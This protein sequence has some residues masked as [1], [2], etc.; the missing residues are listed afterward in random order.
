M[1]PPQATREALSERAHSM[2]AAACS[3]T[4]EDRPGAVLAGQ[5]EDTRLCLA[6]SL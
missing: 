4:A 5:G 2:L 3:M 6:G 1:R